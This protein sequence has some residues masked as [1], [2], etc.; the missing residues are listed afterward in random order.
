MS[1]TFWS[2]GNPEGMNLCNRN[3]YDLMRWLGFTPDY[4]GVLDSAE[5]AARC[6]R[7]LWPESRNLDPGLECIVE[8][9]PDGTPR[10]IE[11]GREENYLHD[12][13]ESLL[14]IA[15]SAKDGKVS[16]G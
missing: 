12:R 7:R 14:R 11:A 1:V 2:D 15:E 10:F 3:A 16:F 5:V 9:R 4:S 13:T 6:R 8:L